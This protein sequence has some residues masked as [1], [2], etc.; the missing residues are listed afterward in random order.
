MGEDNVERHREKIADYQ[1]WKEAWNRP[2]LTALE[3][4]Q[5]FP[6][7]ES[8]HFDFGLLTSKTMRHSEFLLFRLL[9]CL[10]W[11]RKLIHWL[12]SALLN[13]KILTHLN[14]FEHTNRW[15]YYTRISSITLKSKSSTWL[16]TNLQNRVSACIC[17]YMYI[18]HHPL[19]TQFLLGVDYMS[20]S[21][22]AL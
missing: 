18:D 3:G 13:F 21:A 9:C 22:V 8:G 17:T 10:S 4:N 5:S 12:I 6:Y 19:F 14:Y 15:N 11:F 20:K 1:P 7:K 16:V 2:C